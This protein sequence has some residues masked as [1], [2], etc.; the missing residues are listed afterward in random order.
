MLYGSVGQM[1]PAVLSSQ[2]SVYVTFLASFLIWFMFAGLGILWLID[3]R[4]KKELVLHA[5]LA[6]LVAWVF[7][8]MFKTLLPTIRPYKLNGTLPMTLT[9]HSD[10]A[11]PSV[12]SAVAFALSTT[13]LLHDKKLGI[14]FSLAALGVG[15]GRILG[16]VHYPADVVG[17][18]VIGSLIAFTVD[19]V[20]VYNLIRKNESKRQ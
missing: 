13:V 1:N 7:S 11:F 15:I 9:L 3:G 5:F 4:V 14:A 6:M 12:H 16:N 10:G 20:H 2:T 18:L 19:K 8:E 17:G